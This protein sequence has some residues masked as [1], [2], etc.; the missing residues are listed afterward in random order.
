V[1]RKPLEDVV[2]VV[3]DGRDAETEPLGDLLVLEAKGHERQ[4]LPLA[5][6]QGVGS[7]GDGGAFLRRFDDVEDPG[8]PRR[9]SGVAMLEHAQ[10]GNAEVLHSAAEGRDSQLEAADRFSTLQHHEGDA[11]RVAE[12][13]VE[14][15]M[16]VENLV[17]SPAEGIGSGTAE[18]AFGGSVPEN[19]AV[20]S[21]HADG[22]PL[23]PHRRLSFGVG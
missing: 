22:R 21:V 13:V 14:G 6:S 15:V 17:T 19:D 2:D 11:G 23:L 7:R 5:R 10:S 18:N 4:D 16:P 3:P 1:E 12:A 8:P 9:I 20:I